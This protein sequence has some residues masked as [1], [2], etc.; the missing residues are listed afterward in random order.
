M[1]LGL[2]N[3]SNNP[4]PPPPP[5]CFV[6]MY[7]GTQYIL[8]PSKLSTGPR[9]RGVVVTQNSSVTI[10]L[11]L[12]MPLAVAWAFRLTFSPPSSSPSPSSYSSS[13]L[14]LFVYLR[15]RKRRGVAW[16][17]GCVCHLV[18]ILML[19]VNLLLNYYLN[20]EKFFNISGQFCAIEMQNTKFN[21]LPKSPDLF[22]LWNWLA[23]F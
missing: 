12:P 20:M 21:L 15:Y 4:P 2:K 11:F 16:V 14:Q 5:I 23:F 7:Y 8:A 9:T 1:G 13:H 6:Y 22:G 3:N 10:M 17:F 19:N 18:Y